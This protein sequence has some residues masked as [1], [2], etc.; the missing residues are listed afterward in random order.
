MSVLLSGQLLA[1]A[2][3]LAALYAL[4][5]M[6]LNLVYSTVRLFN[7]AHGELVMLGGYIAYWS[8]TK[9]SGISPLLSMLVAPAVGA[10]LGVLIYIVLFQ[11]FL[12]CHRNWPRVSKPIPC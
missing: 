2:L 3:V 11:R 8:F 5:A 7:I 4:V 9:F 12:G 1:A 6:G 10:G